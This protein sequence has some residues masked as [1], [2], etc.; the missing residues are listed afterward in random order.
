MVEA[1]PWE[2]IL[3]HARTSQRDSVYLHILSFGLL[4]LRDAAS[5]GY[6][7]YCTIEA[8]HL[9][10]LPSLI[11]EQNES[12]HDG[13]FHKERSLYLERVDHSI[14]GIDFTLARYAELW[15]RLAELKQPNYGPPN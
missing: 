1:M 5:A 2:P 3:D 7:E 12:R 8:D 4:R 9:H 13:Y 6:T 10:N 11:G 14:P 15:E